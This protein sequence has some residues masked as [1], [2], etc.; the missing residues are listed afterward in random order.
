MGR[1]SDDLVVGN[2]KHIL[3][4]VC[5]LCRHFSLILFLKLLEAHPHTQWPPINHHSP[6]LVWLAGSMSDQSPGV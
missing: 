5:F 2:S 6:S 4:G 3:L 1:M